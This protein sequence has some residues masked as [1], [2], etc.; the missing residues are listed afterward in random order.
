MIWNEALKNVIEATGQKSTPGN[1]SDVLLARFFLVAVFGA[2]LVSLL[3]GVSPEK[4][5]FCPCPFHL[6]TGIDCPGC[7]MTRACIALA[8]GEIGRALQYN[9]LSIG[10]IIFAGAFALLPD[11]IRRFWRN[12]PDKIHVLFTASLL[13]LILGFWAYRTLP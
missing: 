2:G 9:P 11:R 7:G 6:L 4:L 3:L 10:L 12:L 13:A 8:R 5:A 1:G